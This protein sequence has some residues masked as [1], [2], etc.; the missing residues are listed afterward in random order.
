MLKP[1]AMRKKR[2]AQFTVKSPS[3]VNIKFSTSGCM[4]FGVTEGRFLRK[5][6]PHGTPATCKS[7]PWKRLGRWS[8]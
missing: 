2:K 7:G 3:G 1:M 6:V 5:M 8:V 4:E